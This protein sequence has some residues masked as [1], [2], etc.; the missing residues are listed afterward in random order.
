MD[1][2]LTSAEWS[3][4]EH[5]WEQGSLTGRE[6]TERMEAQL[7]WNRST[8]LTHLRRMEGKG[9][10]K[11]TQQDG[12]KTYFPVLSREDAALQET[13]GFLRRVYNGSLSMMMSA[14]TKKERLSQEEIDALYALLDGLEGKE[15]D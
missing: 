8:T 3:V 6:A 14:L 1:K 9:T 11:S 12:V 13:Q 4:M 15:H 2:T 10:V 5:L 7:G